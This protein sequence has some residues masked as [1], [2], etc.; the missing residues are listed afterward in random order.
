[1]EGMTRKNLLVAGAAGV[2]ATAFSA[3][4]MAASDASGAP[5]LPHS[6]EKFHFG[7]GA[8]KPDHVTD[9]GTVTKCTVKNM[10]TLAGSDAAVFLLRLKP[11]GLREP[12]WHPNAWELDYCVSGHVQFTIVDPEDKVATF[13][14]HPGDVAFVPQ[15]W[16]HMIRNVGSTEAVIPITF[17]N[18]NPDDTG[19]STMFGGLPTSAFEETL[20]VKKGTLATARKPAKTLFIVD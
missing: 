4:A 12:H 15:G 17:G 2:A 16:A 6:T 10:P 19:L 11:G 9:Y 13:D 7:L 1:M 5:T 18:N 14:L 20:A 8:A 3:D